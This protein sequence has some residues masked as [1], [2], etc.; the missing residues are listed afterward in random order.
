MLCSHSV[1]CS[2]MHI[3][4]DGSGSGSGSSSEDAGPPADANGDKVS[5]YGNIETRY[6][7]KGGVI[8]MCFDANCRQSTMIKLDRLLEISSRTGKVVQRAESFNNAEFNWTRPVKE[9]DENGVKRIK[10]QLDSTVAVGKP[11]AHQEA[12]FKMVTYV[13]LNN[14]TTMNGNQTIDVM[15]GS[16]KFSIEVTNWPWVADSTTNTLSFGVNMFVK[17]RNGKKRA[18]NPQK[19]SGRGRGGKIS[20]FE[21]GESIFMD[22]PDLCVVDDDTMKE[23]TTVVAPFGSAGISID[24]V[25]PNFQK[26]LYYD[27][28]I[29]DTSTTDEDVSTE[30]QVVREDDDDTPAPTSMTPVTETPAPD[31]SNPTTDL[32]TSTASITAHRFIMLSMIVLALMI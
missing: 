1:T 8:E 22:A 30:A 19:K 6:G 5:R 10:V 29:G 4:E 21:L 20:R 15:R 12:Q 7:K 2:T 23:L 13:Y 3:V 28:V 16:L 27:P 17:N 26:K 9:T 31:T 32:S 25:F 18:K 24:W 11:N 14:G